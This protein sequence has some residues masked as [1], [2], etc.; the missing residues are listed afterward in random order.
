MINPWTQGAVRGVREYPPLGAWLNRRKMASPPYVPPQWAR[1][2]LAGTH[3]Y[4]YAFP[5]LVLAAAQTGL[6]R[7]TVTEDFWLLAVLKTSAG[8]AMAGSDF[9]AQLYEDQTAYKYSK[10]GVNELNF[11]CSAQEPGVLHLP[12]HI[13]AGTPINCRVQ[14]LDGAAVNTVDIVLYGVSNWWRA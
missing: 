7:L 13:E 10:Y 1:L 9:R 2:A 4:W 3:A 8:S 6:T 12:H 11:G 5:S 14:N